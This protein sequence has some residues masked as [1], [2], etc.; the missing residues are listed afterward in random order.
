MFFQKGFEP[1]LRGE[2][3]ETNTVH[4][5]S[6]PERK[7]EVK[8]DFRFVDLGILVHVF[9]KNLTE[10]ERGE[11]GEEVGI[12]NFKKNKL[13]AS[14]AAAPPWWLTSHRVGNFI[15]HRRR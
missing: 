1:E 6:E 13:E 8:V 10:N 14:G 4:T 3:G 2:E 15:P 7:R 9:K 5:E 11:R 12:K